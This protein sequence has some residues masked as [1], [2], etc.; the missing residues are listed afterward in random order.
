ML[1]ERDDTHAGNLTNQD[2]MLSTKAP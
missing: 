2:G 1:F